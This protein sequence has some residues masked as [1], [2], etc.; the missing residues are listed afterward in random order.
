MQHSQTH[1]RTR[2][3]AAGHLRA[4]EAVARHLNF[5]AAAEE[6]ALTQSAVSRQ[7]QALE[8]EVGTS[9]FLRHTRA[10]ELT[11]AGAQLLLAVSQSL[12]RIDGAVRQIRQSAGRKSVSLTTFAS[13]ASMWL[14]PRLEQFQREHPDID[15]RIDASDLAVDLEMA[16]VDLALRYGPRATMPAQA[17]RLFGE[18]LTPVASPWLLKSGPPLKQPGDLA[19]H[20]LIEAG[21]AHRTHLQWL[22]WRRWFEEQ[23]LA[24][25]QPKRWLYF[26]YAYQMVQAAL[27]GQGVV[28]ARLPMVAESLST[29][30]L[31][32][33]LPGLRMN[34]PMAYWLIL[35]PRSDQRPEIRAFRDWLLAES[36]LTREATGEVPDPDTVDDID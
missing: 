27:T 4:F 2:P 15:I 29:G 22:T 10:V 35:G 28:L 16:D 12:P 5:R 8:D 7:I 26:N 32:E 21:D 9:L 17:L 30:D 18:Q 24:R 19:Q 33:P 3:I 23:Q 31:V 36:R 1:L 34:S 14:I 25:L 6:M 13:F 20:A 11:S